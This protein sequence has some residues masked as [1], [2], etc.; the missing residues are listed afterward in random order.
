MTFQSQL[1]LPCHL[2]ASPCLPFSQLYLSCILQHNPPPPPLTETRLCQNHMWF[3]LC[4]QSF[5]LVYK[6]VPT[7]AMHRRQ[8]DTLPPAHNSCLAITSP[9]ILTFRYCRQ[10]K[11]GR[12]TPRNNTCADGWLNTKYENIVLFVY[13]FRC[14]C[15]HMA[16][17]IIN[18]VQFTDV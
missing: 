12:Q 4:H 17:Y 8:Q 13:M 15:K 3:V 7:T 10:P 14:A 16:F 9:D 6:S 18:Q 5:K 11:T 1:Q 2:F